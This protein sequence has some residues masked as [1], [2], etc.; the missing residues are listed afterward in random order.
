MLVIN[1]VHL[2]N[3]HINSAHTP[4]MQQTPLEQS[5]SS[6]KSSKPAWF[7][8]VQI[9]SDRSCF[10]SLLHVFRFPLMRDVFCKGSKHL[11]KPFTLHILFL[12]RELLAPRAKEL[13]LLFLAHS[14]YFD[15][16]KLS[17]RNTSLHNT[18]WSNSTRNSSLQTDHSFLS[19]KNKH[20]NNI[21]GLLYLRLHWF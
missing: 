11:W 8:L 6:A 7:S 21:T 9:T 17:N 4:L 10:V 14:I 18:T 1:S 3:K 5:L 16:D 20:Y 13:F 12:P 2:I 15:Q 19:T